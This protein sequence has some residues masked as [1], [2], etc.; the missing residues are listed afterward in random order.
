MGSPRLFVFFW[1]FPPHYPLARTLGCLGRIFSFFSHP[2][3]RGALLP[4]RFLLVGSRGFVLVVMDLFSPP[5][6]VQHDDRF[7]VGEANGCTSS[8]TTRYRHSQGLRSTQTAA[9]GN[10]FRL[11]RISVSA[12]AHERAESTAGWAARILFLHPR[13]V[14]V[15]F[16]FA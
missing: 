2:L 6:F 8:R 16:R 12:R 10:S 7:L 9:S 1:N 5:P 14:Y 11:P 4:R 13:L 15:I 3:S